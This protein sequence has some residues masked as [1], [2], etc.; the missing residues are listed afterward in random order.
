LVG[1]C[2]ILV[3]RDAHLAAVRDLA[4][5]TAGGEGNLVVVSG[6]AGT[7][8]SR[9][10]R[11]SIASLGRDW[12]VQTL[13]FEPDAAPFDDLIGPVGAEDTPARAIGT[14][15]GRE[16]RR[17]AEAA[18]LALVL[19]DLERADPLLIGALVS[20][21]DV[22]VD[23]PVLVLATYRVGGPG[24]DHSAAIAELLR[25]PNAHDIRIRPLS[26]DGVAVM[27]RAMG[28]DPS[29]AELDVLYRRTDGNPFFVEELLHAPSGELPWT[30]TEA[31]LDRLAALS[32]PAREVARALACALTA[33]PRPVVE[34]VVPDGPAGCS[35]LIATGIAVAPT[36]DEITL[37]HALLG[38]VV[39]AHVSASDRRELCGRLA[40]ALEGEPGVAPARL[41]RLWDSAG[42]SDRAARWAA[43]AADAAARGRQYRTASELYRL[44]LARHDDE[45]D[46]DDA[47][48]RAA[49]FDRAAVAAGWAG[50]GADAYEWATRADA[51]YRSCAGEEWR[52]VAMWLNP[53]IDK[54]PKPAL[55]PTALAPDAVPRL[56]VEAHEATRRKEYAAAAELARQALAACDERTDAGLT[57][58]TNAAR[59]LAAAGELRE[60]EAVLHRL[61]AVA[62][63]SRRDEALTVALTAQSFVA[64]GRGDMDDCLALNRQALELARRGEQGTWAIE[65][66]IALILAYLGELDEVDAIVA[67]LREQHDALIDEFVQL[68]ACVVDIERGN[69]ARARERLERLQ[70]VY[71]L[72]VA[73]FTAG[74]LLARA[75]WHYAGAEHEQALL[76]AAEVST[77]TGDLFHA[78]AL[79]LLTVTVRAARALGDDRA[80]QDARTVIDDALRRGAGRG[81]Q[82]A[83]AWA[84]GLEAS[85]RGAPLDAATLLESAATQLE[86]G[87]RYREAAETWLD[88]AEVAGIDTETRAHAL[89]RAAD[90]ARPRGLVRVLTRLDN[91]ARSGSTAPR[92]PGPLD[93]LSGRQREIAELV[94]AGRT[95]REIGEALFISEHTV[96]NQLVEVFA[97]LAI[98]RRSEIARLIDGPPR[99]PGAV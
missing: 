23:A 1:A 94:A 67:S 8:K 55:D 68:P 70:G 15:L 35:E 7:G 77:L 64:A 88:L 81:F 34:R 6:E 47:L 75:R 66:G 19:E 96:R 85:T 99:N 40:T 54:V 26:R 87:Q 63:A 84:H 89:E 29:D 43:V 79:G 27:A 61:R 72:G 50:L 37:R 25:V 22:L 4:A 20:T 21:L 13:R 18:P 12:T 3:E 90:L 45:R 53:A 5:R 92:A 59:R 76:A 57:S 71:A 24:A 16:L 41:A 49:L 31:V 86:A 52:A 69:Q 51:L 44:A 30:L 58:M 38:D 10:T 62:A 74:V 65:V 9:L 93:V 36:P 73:E 82:A 33:L 97:K 32:A 60:A 83:A 46:A 98:S 2:P 56:L 11:E 42:D 28:S 78:S 48:D 39:V 14:A 80:E 91:V 17:R 95:N